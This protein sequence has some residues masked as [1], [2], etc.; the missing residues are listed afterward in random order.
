[1]QYRWCFLFGAMGMLVVA[2]AK[3]SPEAAAQTDSQA[4]SA[5]LQLE[6]CERTVAKHA[7]PL[8][9]G[10]FEEP[11]VSDP[12]YLS[13][14]PNGEPEK[15]GWG[16]LA[17][18]VDVCRAGWTSGGYTVSGAAYEGQQYLDLVGNGTT[19][20]ITQLVSVAAGVEHTLRFAYANNPLSTK[21]AAARVKISNCGQVL[22]S[23]TFNHDT[24]TATDLA[25]TVFEERITPK[26]SSVTL[27]IES[28]YSEGTGG[29][30][31]DGIT[32]SAQQTTVSSTR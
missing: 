25:W 12:G 22:L 31:L 5:A 28:T 11:A 27:E 4:T 14:A 1:M 24:S 26:V 9:N 30:L 18:G 10:G 32:L 29:I 20:T 19:G 7:A 13:L 15:F 6:P 16:V 17:D 8:F 3:E 23:K 21:N 2:C